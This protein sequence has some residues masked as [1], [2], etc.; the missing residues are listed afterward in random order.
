MKQWALTLTGA[1]LLWPAARMERRVEVGVDV[2][3]VLLERPYCPAA[4]GGSAKELRAV[5]GPGPVFVTV[6]GASSHPSRKLLVPLI[7]TTCYISYLG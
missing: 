5:P 6:K 3:R 7:A 2:A 1:V 4:I